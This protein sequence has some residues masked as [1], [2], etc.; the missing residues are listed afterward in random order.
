MPVSDAVLTQILAQ[1]EAMQVSQQAMQAKLDDLALTKKGETPL[2]PRPI[3]THARSGS[4]DSAIASNGATTPSTSVSFSPPA[5]LVLATQANGQPA[6]PLTD[7][8]REKLLYPGRVNLTSE[9]DYFVIVALLSFRGDRGK[10]ER[11]GRWRVSSHFT[12]PTSVVVRHESNH[13]ATRLVG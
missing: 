2:E 3:P 8:E 5:P 6:K 13:D 7:K 10:N 9:F 11:G 12:R 1:L 4:T